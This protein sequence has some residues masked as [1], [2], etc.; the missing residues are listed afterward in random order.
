MSRAEDSGQAVAELQQEL[1]QLRRGHGV[2]ARDVIERVGPRLAELFGIRPGTPAG[3]ARQL[4][5][6]G[7]GERVVAL[8]PDLRM[9][10]QAAFGLPPA[11]QSRFLRERMEWLGRELG[12]DPRTAI[13]RVESGL[14]L[15]AEQLAVRSAPEPV[16]PSESVFA[17]DGWYI[18]LLRAAVSLHVDPVRLLETRRI[19]ATVDGLDRVRT[20]W[21]VPRVDRSVSTRTIGVAMM[22][23]GELIT[24]PQTTT[25]TYWS[26]WIR[27]PRP[28][29]AGEHHEYQVQVTSLPRPL[30]SRYYVLSPHRRCDEFELRAKFDP[31]ATPERI[32]QLGG[33]PFRMIDEAI[34]FGVP[35]H[36]DAVGEVV[37]RFRNLRQGLSYGLQWRDAAAPQMTRDATA[38]A[39]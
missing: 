25:A 15:L 26:G 29:K 7:I 32:W 36:V 31:T 10:V 35:L 16:P 13:R 17:P 2:H 8:P 21:S 33:V 4:L 19:V 5:V 22:Y 18:D 23:G 9:A 14:A 27:L 3:Q 1:V 30:L 6:Q 11:S 37:V 39:D 20:S 12:R 38:V 28:L 24:D 34:E